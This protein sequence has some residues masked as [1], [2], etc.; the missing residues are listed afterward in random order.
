MRL[1]QRIGNNLW[2]DAITLEL[3]Q[4][5][6]YDTFIDQGHHTKFNAPSGYKK[7]RVHFSFDVKHDSIHK[8]RLV[9]NGHLIQIPVDSVY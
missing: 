1:D 5:D 7:I 2:G 8:A 4:I 6:D 9:A 3:T